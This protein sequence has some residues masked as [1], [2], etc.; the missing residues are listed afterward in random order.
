MTS[1]DWRHR[2]LS[3]PSIHH[4]EACIRGTRNADSTIVASVAVSSVDDVVKQLSQ[5]TREDVQAALAFLEQSESER[6]GSV[7]A[8]GGA[9]CP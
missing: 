9:V 2:V 7:V 6:A 4:G 5:I 1:D 3:D 8:G